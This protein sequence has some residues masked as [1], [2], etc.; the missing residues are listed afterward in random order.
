[1]K[2]TCCTF[3]PESNLLVVGYSTSVFG[4][5]EMPGSSNMHA[6]GFPE[7]KITSVAIITSGE[8]LAFGA[9]KLGQLLA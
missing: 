7:E 5:W 1:M 2:V 4:L 9:S 8:R 6:L 3:H